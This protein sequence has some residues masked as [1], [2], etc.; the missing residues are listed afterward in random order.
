V[1]CLLFLSQSG[2]NALDLAAYEGHLAMVE[3]L[4]GHGFDLEAKD[5]V[6]LQFSYKFCF[7]V[8]SSSVTGAIR[9]FSLLH[10]NESVEVSQTSVITKV[11]QSGANN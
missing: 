8:L 10:R 2:E 5:N 11:V 9:A 6:R 7:S 4:L 1:R 3:Y